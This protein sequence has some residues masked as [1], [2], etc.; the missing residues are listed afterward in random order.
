ADARSG[1]AVGAYNLIFRT[2]D[3]GTT[4]QPWFDRT[5]N[6]KFFNLYAM[7]KAAGELYIAGEGG[8]VLKLDA[9]AERF[10]S[11]ATPYSGSFFGVADGGAAAVVLGLAS[12][13]SRT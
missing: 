9:A 4:W 7:R 3:G 5:E 2:N 8:L 10:K 12:T 11:L 1:F 13:S 6:P